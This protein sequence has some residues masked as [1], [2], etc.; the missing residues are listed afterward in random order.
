MH[1]AGRSKVICPNGAAGLELEIMSDARLSFRSSAPIEL[2]QSTGVSGTL[3][4]A[5]NGST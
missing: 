5:T 4:S 2:A 1:R 3:M